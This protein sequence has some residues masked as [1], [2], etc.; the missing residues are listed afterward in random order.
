MQAWEREHCEK[1]VASLEA[2]KFVETDLGSEIIIELAH[3][4][5]RVRFCDGVM[6]W[7][8]AGMDIG[9]E[10]RVDQHDIDGSAAYLRNY[11]RKAV[12]NN[13]ARIAE[14]VVRGAKQRL[15]AAQ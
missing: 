12:K 2:A 7:Q 4:H 5:G 14:D 1:L 3:L 13:L 10:K 9:G 11:G 6:C 15:E 8:I